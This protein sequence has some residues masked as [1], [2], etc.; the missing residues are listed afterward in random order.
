[1]SPW[2]LEC[3]RSLKPK[4]SNLLR[5][6]SQRL[7]YN[8]VSI[9]PHASFCCPRVVEDGS[10]RWPWSGYGLRWVRLHVV[11]TPSGRAALR[12]AAM[13]AGT[14]KRLCG[15]W[16]LDWL[17]LGLLPLRL[18]L[19]ASLLAQAL[20]LARRGAVRLRHRHL[21]VFGCAAR[22]TP[23]AP[24]PPFCVCPPAVRAPPHSRVHALQNWSEDT[25]KWGSGGPTAE[26]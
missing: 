23:A 16:R 6:A 8:T 9:S 20:G 18:C 5:V 17:L 15:V 11:R 19:F 4:L 10:I 13:I 21:C 3:L 12:V 2:G 25:E 1:M 14:H 26:R 22:A 24:T 7:L